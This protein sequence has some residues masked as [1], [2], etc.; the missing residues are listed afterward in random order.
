MKLFF[1]ISLLFCSIVLYAQKSVICTVTD[2]NKE[3]IAGAV[4]LRLDKQSSKVINYILSDVNGKF[5][6]DKFD[7]G[8]QKIRIEFLGYKPYEM[9][10]Q[11]APVVLEPLATALDAVIVIAKPT[12]KMGS[13]RLIYSV[14]GS[15]VAKDND[16]WDVLKHAPL[17][18]SSND[19][20][21]IIGKNATKIYINGKPSKLNHESLKAYLTSLPASE[22]KSIE[23]ITAPDVSY[24]GSG[25]FGVLNVIVKNPVTDG[26]LG[27][28][29]L[30][31][32]QAYY[33][34]QIASAY[35]D[36]RKGKFGTKVSLYGN[37]SNP[38]FT[39]SSS[40]IFAESQAVTNGISDTYDSN[41]S[42]GGSIELNYE[43]SPKQD[44][45][46]IV[47]LNVFDN[48]SRTKSRYD[49]GHLNST[50]IDS[51]SRNYSNAPA[52]GHNLSSSLLYT[53]NTGEK[54]SKLEL[55]FDYIN[56][57]VNRESDNTFN[58]SQSYNFT[59]NT[60][61]N[62][63]SFIGTAKYT[64]VVTQKSNLTFGSEWYYSQSKYADK[65]LSSYV[66]YENQFSFDETLASLYAVY[67]QIWSEKF[68]TRVGVR[69]EYSKYIG[70]HSIDGQM[71]NVDSWTVY[72]SISAAYL[73]S[74]NHN[75]S[76]ALQNRIL[77]PSF[78]E[79]NPYITYQSPTS[80]KAGN[81][82]LK[83]ATYMYYQLNYSYKHKLFFNF[84]LT[85]GKDLTYSYTMPYDGNKSTTTV[86]NASKMINPKFTVSYYNQFFNNRLQVN[87]TAFVQHM[88]REINVRTVN[89][90]E[91]YNTYGVFLDNTFSL[92]PKQGLKLN[93]YF[94]YMSPIISQTFTMSHNWF[95]N[96]SLMKRFSD[97]NV[98]I[99]AQD[100]FRT[101]QSHIRNDIFGLNNYSQ[102]YL[103]NQKIIISIGYTFGNRKVKKVKPTQSSADQVKQRIE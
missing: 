100:I 87:Y 41:R 93:A 5:I 22:I 35:V 75:L 94:Q 43:I 2:E 7:E 70:T 82:F 86:I 103:D 96:L 40:Q 34:S 38:L 92:L 46:A 16:T 84:S 91:R 14:T 44:L 27:S 79:L 65:F 62:V 13:D 51:I 6:L 54:G 66:K 1:T 71:L 28:I 36:I 97:F 26:V 64:Y 4:I 55:E 37:N 80:T 57:K 81:P 20:I 8:S 74:K 12:I 61:M 23:V 85:S 102:S 29:T 42:V 76:F 69:A 72:P 45:A 77:R 68:N 60:P 17:I 31:D 50:V 53:L 33:N 48:K 78:N 18:S 59:Q 11:T 3:P 39:Q 89:V 10:A 88:S 30:I 47:S 58:T 9:T 63:N 52:N 56:Y 99:S 25:D 49:Y 67:G 95:L 101:M 24:S 15:L 32:E 21:S 19:D 83:P 98:K 90:N 73:I